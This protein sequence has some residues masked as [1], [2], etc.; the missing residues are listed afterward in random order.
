[1]NSDASL[2]EAPPAYGAG[3]QPSPLLE[4]LRKLERALERGDATEHTHRPALKELLE[5]LNGQIVATNE[6]KRSDCG[7]PDYV[8]SRKRDQL[9]LG[10]VEAKAIGTDLNVIER[11]DQLKRYLASLPN[12]LL[13]DYIEFRW[14]VEGRKRATFRIATLSPGDKLTPAATEAQERARHLLEG[15]LS[16]KPVDIASAEELAKRLAN[17]TH[18]IRDI[19]I[20]T[21]QTNATSQQLRDWRHAFAVTLLPE[22]AEQGDAKKETKAVA[23][24]ADMFAQTLAYGL[25]SARASSSSTKF[26]REKA[27]RLIPRTNPF[28]RTFFEQITGAALDDEPFA[29][30]VE[31]LIRTLDHADMARILE[32][33]GKR[34]RRRDPVVHF[35]ETFLQAY[36][37]KLRELRGVYYTPEPVVNYIVQSID[38][39][40]KDKFGIKAGLADHAKIT[41]TRQEGDREISDETHRVLILDPA[42]GTATFLYTVLDFIRSQFKIK[43]NAGQWGS[44]VHE[45]LLPRL[46]GFELL[47]A[48]YAVAHFKLGLALAAMDEEPLF[49]QQ[50]SYEPRAH[51]RVN[52]FLTNTLEDLERTTE[53][54]GPLRALSDEANSAYEVK[55]HQPVLVVLGNPPY[56]GHSA[57]KGEW[58]GKLVR[59]YY[60]C[61]GKPLGEK[62]PKWLQDDYV[63]FLRWGQWRIEQT[64]QGILAFITNHGYLDN[65]TFRGMRQHLMQTF[66]EI[67][68]LDLHG[69]AKKKETVPGSSEADKNVFDIQQGVAIGIFVKHPLRSSGHESAQTKVSRLKPVVTEKPSAIVRHCDL[70][71]ARR[72]TKYDWLDKNQIESTKWTKLAPAAPHYLFIPQDTKRLKEYERGWKV[73]EMMPVNGVGMTTARDHFVTDFD[74]QPLVLRARKFRDSNETDSRLCQILGISEKQGWN[75]AA[76]RKS[77]AGEADLELFIKP[78]LYRPFDQRFIFYHDSLVWRTVKH[79]MQ[80]VK[81]KENIGLITSRSVE[82]GEGWEHVF[83]TTQMIQHHSMSLKEVNYLFP[84]YLYPNGKLPEEDLFAHDNA[85]RPNL[86]AEFIKAFC[87]K[88]RVK[89]VPDGLGRP[90]KREIGP[91]LIFHYAYA[92]FHSPT[93]RE[94]YA[95]FL[96][97]DFPRLP[98]TG[99]FKLFRAL[100]DTGLQLVNLHARREGEGQGPAFP[101]PGD[102]EIN[103]VRYQPAA[104]RQKGRV[105]INDRQYFEDVAEVVWT[106]PIGGYRPAQRWLHDRWEK[107]KGKPKRKLSFADITTYARIV[108]A[109]GE[110][111]KLMAQIDKTIAAHGGW[112]LS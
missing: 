63:K 52:I 104:G 68:V 70:W 112:P 27:Q 67:Y 88:L 90:G 34:G 22:L 10:Y 35:Y 99:N 21:F 44:Y 89:F 55:K 84:I 49:R 110:T 96:R 7:A 26:T 24:F 85:R 93:Y 3:G 14:F 1:M 9:S 43:K 106:F 40:L 51:E 108:Y 101:V 81:P 6:P 79:V 33:F 109:L 57:N 46:F 105:W 39:L 17:L 31:D 59:D 76:A 15:F 111:R 97:A 28:L 13:T 73:T 100:A 66:D 38:R 78:I 47:M 4:Y 75:I 80:H 91:E 19:I 53:Q 86:S 8:I 32:D 25:F 71:G 95:E 18:V 20:G 54:L 50:W 41:V 58:I 60:F 65:P 102:N 16:Q 48:P 69:N 82:I 98:L 30:F 77:L 23:E 42:T 61:D 5:T 37:P 11:S 36:D 83:S 74:K 45:H 62:N 12:L 94:R 92:V 107:K 29:G 103:N 56:S 87:A 72:Q 64:G 2:R